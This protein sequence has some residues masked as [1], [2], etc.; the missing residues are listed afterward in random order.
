[1]DFNVNGMTCGG[2]ARAV[3]NAIRN[4]DPDASVEVDLA[5]KRVSVQSKA[6]AAS[7]EAAIT[8]A[9]YEVSRQP[10]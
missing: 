2:C 5:V 7:L 3:T 9:G 8:D 10:A 1:M 4:V 6:E